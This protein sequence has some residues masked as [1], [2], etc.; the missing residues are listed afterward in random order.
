M[1]HD[2]T[3][4]YASLADRLLALSVPDEHGPLFR[5]SPC[6]VWLGWRNAKGY[7]KLSVRKN[8]RVT[9][10][11]A[12]L[13]AREELGGRPVAPGMHGDHAC[14]CTSC[15]NPGHVDDKTPEENNALRDKRKRAAE[16][17]KWN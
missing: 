12:H 2:R 15:I 14:N 7:G 5:G 16:M 3:K 4:R 9:S 13:A 10:V 8:G 1:T 17:R 11:W 6:W